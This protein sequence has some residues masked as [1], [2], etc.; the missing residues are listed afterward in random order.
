MKRFLLIISLILLTFRFSFSQDGLGSWTL[1]YN[2]SNARV[3]TVAV[4]PNNQSIIYFGSL[5]N[6]LVKSTNGGLNWTVINTGLTYNHVFTMAIAKSN[7]NIIYA[8]TDSLG[9][10]TTSG[11]YRSS[12]GGSNWTYVS[13]NGFDSKSIQ[14]ILVDPTDPNVVYVGVFTGLADATTGLFK[15]TNGGT[16]WTASNTG[17]VNK[18]ILSLAM[19]P[20]NHNVIYAGSSLIVSSSSGPVTIYKSVNAGA[21]WTAIISGIPQ[22][23]TDNNPVRCLSV[24]SL[25]TNVVLAG[26]FMNATALTGG[27]YVTTN[28][29]TLWTQKNTGCPNTV[30]YLC[31]SCLIKPGSSTEFYSGWDYSAPPGTNV[32]V[33]RT[34]DQG[35]SWTLFA[36][37]SLLSTYAIRG[38]AFKTTGNPTLYAGDAGLSTTAF[39]GTGLYEYSWLASGVSDPAVP[40]KYELSQNYPNPFNPTT[41]IEYSLLKPGFVTIK[42]YDAAGKEVKVLINEFKAAGKYNVEFNGANLVSGVYFY[43]IRSNEFFDTKKMLLVK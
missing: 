25:D 19:N 29:G 30:S 41:T 6:G 17:M 14:A 11:I 9:A 26:L 16:N 7:S 3:Y 32:C 21:S 39:S 31:R 27:M 22:T 37:G 10:W 5:D 42:V 23:S 40:V 18:N 8:G 38:M 12:D 1:T 15:T 28:G 34:T 13:N 36:G 20:L 43:Q 2:N 35:T 4:D 33:Y 24:S